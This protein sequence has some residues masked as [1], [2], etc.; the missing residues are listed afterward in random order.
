MEYKFTLESANAVANLAFSKIMPCYKSICSSLESYHEFMDFLGHFYKNIC[1]Y[2]FKQ[3]I[4]KKNHRP[5]EIHPRFEYRIP[6]SEYN[7]HSFEKIERD[8]LETLCDFSK[9]FEQYPIK[10]LLLPKIRILDDDN[11]D[12]FMTSHDILN[13]LFSLHKEGQCLILQPQERPYKAVTIFNAFPNFDVALRQADLWPAVMFWDNN[14]NYAFV[15]IKDEEE[16]YNLYQIVQDEPEPINKIKKIAENKKKP[17]H[18]IFHLSD[19]H[20]GAKDVKMAAR[21]LKSLIK[22]RFD[23][24]EANDSVNFVITGDSVHSPNHSN[25]SDYRDFSEHLKEH[26]GKKLIRILGNH[27]INNLGLAIFQGKKRIANIVGEYP[28]I[29]ILEDSKAIL[30]LFNSNTSGKLAEGKIGK[31]QMAEMGNQLDKVKNLKDYLLIAVMHHHLLPIPQ[32]KFYDRK[33]YEKIL[34]DNFLE[35]AI[36]L[37]DADLFMEWLKERN[38]K[39]VLHGHRHIQFMTE[40]KDSGINVIS[41][42]SSTGQITHQNKDKTYISYNLIKIGE[43]TVTCSQFAE[44]ILGAGAK[45]ILPEHI[46]TEPIQL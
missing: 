1:S 12:D 44:E 16:L 20:F 42:G 43:E 40:H 41:C 36:K 5:G 35:L 6:Q 38:V 8:L 22:V 26:Y 31:E 13:Q 17:S 21:R 15:P 3:D 27:D 9:M 7:E 30:L 45:H 33:W 34:P 18:Y 28:K 14:K 10:S 2:K 11:D 32:P 39:I 37:K 4:K 46:R 19:L 24:I 25:E 29:E 23:S